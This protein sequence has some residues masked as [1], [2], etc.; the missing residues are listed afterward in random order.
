MKVLTKFLS[1]NQFP[2][3]SPTKPLIKFSGSHL[4]RTKSR[5]GKEKSNYVWSR[6]KRERLKGKMKK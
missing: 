6:S 3:S 1:K 5:K 2:K 4:S